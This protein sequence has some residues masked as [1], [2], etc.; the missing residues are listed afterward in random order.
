M[1]CQKR[2]MVVLLLALFL[3]LVSSS[4]LAVNGCYVYPLARE[5]LY[6]ISGISD[7][8]AEGDCD[9]YSDCSL[10]QYFIPS[11]DCRSIPQCEQVTCNVDC[12]THAL[13]ICQQL[14]GEAVPVEEYDARC[15]PGCCKISA[16]FCQF[17]LNQYECTQKAQ[18]LGVTA[19]SQILFDNRI[20]MTLQQC[21]TLYCQAELNPA[22]LQGF[23]QNEGGDFIEGAIIRLE[24]RAQETSSAVTGNYEFSSLSPGTYLVQVEKEGYFSLSQSVSLSSGEEQE[25]NFTLTRAQGLGQ[26]SG[27]VTQQEGGSAIP[28][29][30]ISWSGPVTGQVFADAAGHYEI[31][32]LPLGEYTFTASKIGFNSQQQT[33]VLTTLPSDLDFQL[34]EVSFVG[35]RGITNV[36]FDQ[37][38]TG[39]PTYGVSIY[40]DGIFKGYSQYP[41]GRFQIELVA[42]EHQLEASYQQYHGRETIQISETS[43][44]RDILLTRYVGECTPPNPPKDVEALYATPSLGKKEVSLQW[45]KPCPE[46]IGYRIEKKDTL[47]GAEETIFASPAET[48]RLDSNV[49]WGKTYEYTITAIY[50]EAVSEHA[51]EAT[52]TL[53]N[54]ACE[55]KYHTD[56]GWESFCLVGNRD[57][58]KTVWTCDN[59][60]ELMPSLTCADRDGPGDDYYCAQLSLRNAECKNA[61]QCSLGGNPFG[62]YYSRDLCYGG[63]T[64]QEAENYCYYDPSVSIVNQCQS[65]FPAVSSCFD[66]KSK[67]ACQTNNCLAASCSWLDAASNVN[68]I[69]DYSAI[70]LPTTVSTETG[71]GYCIENEYDDDDT[72]SLCSPSA[73]LFENYYCTAQICSGLG[74]CFSNTELSACSSC[75]DNPSST[76]NCYT[77]TTQLECVSGRG[78]EQNAFGEITLSEDQCG[79]GR[80]VWAGAENG[81]A[82]GACVKDGDADTQDDC[83]TFVSGGERAACEIDNSPP[84]TT[85]IPGGITIIS[86]ASQNLT[87][88]GD[89]RFHVE[90]SQR[91]KMGIVG[92]CLIDADP[93]IQAVCT[94]F[95]EA[96]YPGVSPEE[97]ITLNLFRSPYL[98]EA[99]NGKTYRLQFYSKDKYKNRED[100]QESFVFVD[101]VPPAFEIREHVQTNGDVTILTSYL[102]GMNEPMGCTFALTGVLPISETQAQFVPREEQNKETSF[103]NLRGILYTLNVSCEDA[104]GNENIQQKNYTFDLEER[105]DIVNP[106]FHGVLSTTSIPFQVRTASGSR[107]ELYTTATNEKLADFV[108]DEGGKT[109]QTA[110]IPG[111][112]E[113]EYAAEQKV[114]CQELLTDQRYEDYFDFTLDF[115]P[116]STQIVLREGPLRE[117]RPTAFGWEEYFIEYALADFECAAQGFPCDKTYYC[118]GEDCDI[119]PLTEYDEY[120]ST[121]NLVNSTEICYY[122][123]DEINNIVYSPFCGTILIEGY[124]ITL[125]NPALHLYHDEQWG[126]SNNPVF[127]VRFFTKVPTQECRYDFVPGFDYGSIPLFKVL[128][129]DAQN[130]Y[131]LAD[132]PS[133]S[134]TTAYAEEGGIKSIYVQCKNAEGTIGPEQ[135]INVEYDPS[136]PSIVNAEAIPNPLLEGNSVE[137]AVATNDKTLCKYSDSGHIEYYSMNFVF[138]GAEAELVGQDLSTPLILREQHQQQFFVSSFT[139]LQ[140]EYNLTTM[141]RNGAGDLSELGTISF[142]VDY[143]Q[144]GGI[145][146]LEPNQ[147]YLASRNVTLRIDT[148]KNALCEY[149]LNGTSIAFTGGGGRGHT[150]ELFN[151][152]EGHHRYPV[153]CQMGDH[154]VDNVITFVVDLTPP[155]ITEIS[156][157]EY[158]CGQENLSL[159][160]YTTDENISAY[161]YELYDVGIPGQE[162]VSNRSSLPL[163]YSSY[164]PLSANASRVVSLASRGT[165]VRNGTVAAQLPLRIPATGLNESHRYIARVQ[166]RDA[167]GNL[168]EY[169]E[170]NGVIVVSSNYSSCQE[171]TAAPRV[172]FATNDSCT[173]SFVEIHCE[174]ATGCA[175]ILYGQ[176]ASSLSCNATHPYNGIKLSFDTNGWLCY[177][178][179]DVNGNN[180][181][182]T[183]SIT[184][185]DNDADHIANTCD[186]CTGTRA[187]A[188]ADSQGCSEGEVPETEKAKDTDGDALPDYWEKTYDNEQCQLHYASVD[189]D[190]DGLADG[191]EDYDGDGYTN[192]Q[193]YT[194]HYNPCLADAPPKKEPPKINVTLP[195]P[196]PEEPGNVL[197][198]TILILGLLLTLGGTGYLIYF[199]F[200][201]PAAV[202]SKGISLPKRTALPFSVESKAGPPGILDS[203]KQKIIQLQKGQKERVQSRQRQ[204]IFA[205]FGK[206]STGIPHLTEAIKAKPSLPKLQQLAQTYVQHK[207]EIKPGLRSEEKSIFAKLEGIAKQTKEKKINEVADTKDA[208]AIFGKLKELS[209]KRKGK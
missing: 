137:L 135:K 178:V 119:V 206:K 153:R 138:P 174:D 185:P 19:P 149:K 45:V 141:C 32:A 29:V 109:H 162:G 24:G 157:G 72:C 31:T 102:V 164:S 123:T 126:I 33:R 144:L 104:Q 152:A 193:E 156:D 116:P 161:T 50:G 15:S 179:Q 205:A 8:E 203:W 177:T 34:E 196:L 64:A 133:S 189:S 69:I 44:E 14:G 151:L 140:K 82:S 86:S 132:F 113:R 78:I 98:Q 190:N 47:T 124:G 111:F 187:G 200:Y 198:W 6:C 76:A 131:L 208:E 159:M 67:D 75:G 37:S 7:T 3:L 155:S 197:A 49:E 192:Y 68:P 94:S 4:A 35:L 117:E 21:N 27:V 194:Q 128:S 22:R 12:E 105:I 48:S 56:T 207:E 180:H 167:A 122:S 2:G 160:V 118:L 175:N 30:T 143:T 112:V 58:R 96:A 1:T 100:L 142:I 59:Q 169:R 61:G 171:D 108:S 201:S 81:F 106:P 163:T 195:P 16:L 129:P 10:S 103:P 41:G 28:G 36:D 63:S 17:N 87:F 158:T 80:C 97:T 52:I 92:Y 130:R 83:T 65:C 38:G 199:Y 136:A 107:C 110:A 148:S 70:N 170:S 186:Q 73:E 85:I 204:D 84:R 125:E 173:A 114:V 55:E 79:W 42:G 146:N 89:D 60:N 53:G 181:S 99:I 184:F 165:L 74:R 62:L 93:N 11:S 154:V 46:V 182:G 115:T 66:Y 88:L 57:T 202:G 71:S 145:L 101:N 26:I 5:D 176:H 127:D 77:Y 20:G 166:A 18:Q 95:E 13:G 147:V 39:V 209:R 139:G 54:S 168:G 40:I 191:V 134:G 9:Q 183:R 51:A 121:L 188:I 120:A 23:I 43:L 25:Q 150:A 91:N 172:I 90:G